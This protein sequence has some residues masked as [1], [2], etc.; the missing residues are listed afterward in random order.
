MKRYGQKNMTKKSKS[1]MYYIYSFSRIVIGILFIFSGYVKMVDPYGTALKFEEYF[2]S[3]G[4]DF[5]AP[6]STVF[7]FL[8]NLAEFVLGWALLLGIQMQLTAWGALLFISFFTILTFWL[9]YALDI[10]AL[11]NRCFDKN[12]EIF[13]VTDCGC[14]GDFIKLDNYQ[15]FYKNI[16]FLLFTIIIFSQRKKHKP[17]KWYYITQW[18]PMLLVAGFSFFVQIYCYRHEPWHDFRP[19][20]IGNFIAGETYSQAPEVDYVFQYKSNT[21]DSIKEITMDELSLIAEDSVQNADLENNYTYHDRVEKIIKLGINAPLADFTVM[22]MNHKNDIKN[23]IITSPDYTFII[24]I[25]DVTKVTPEKFAT[26]NNLIRELESSNL[27]YVVI[28]GSLQQETELF[29]KENNAAIYFYFSDITPLKT[30]IRNNPGVILLKEGYVIDK[31]SFR[32]IPS[33]ETIKSSMPKYE[34]NVEKYKIKHPPVLP[35]GTGIME[36]IKTT[37]AETMPS[38]ENEETITE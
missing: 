23:S 15:T 17:Q 1:A 19:W 20:K 18:F 25:H 30:A 2:I 6:A 26:V 13:V 36:I 38:E 11:V 29:N 3:F 10:V 28:T 34:R 14:F 35:D 22:D 7:A 24:F 32:D 37:D 4:M 8:M 27:N 21:T 9:A 16:V 33:L 31:W 12:F 5:M